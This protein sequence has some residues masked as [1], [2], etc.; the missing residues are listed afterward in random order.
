[1]ASLAIPLYVAQSLI[2]SAV[3]VDENGVSKIPEL[4]NRSPTHNESMLISGD[5]ISMGSTNVEEVWWTWS[6]D[7]VRYDPKLWVK[8]L[9]GS[10]YVY[11]DCPLNIAVGMIQTASPGRYVHNVL[12]IGWPTPTRAQRVSKGT[13]KRKRSQVVKLVR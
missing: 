6:M 3:P 11:N 12:M 5:P 1:M 10:V 7:F 2:P 13:G 4:V 8:F 9:D